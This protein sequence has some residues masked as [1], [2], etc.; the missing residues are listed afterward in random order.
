MGIFEKL[1]QRKKNKTGELECSL[2]NRGGEGNNQVLIWW[3]C[4]HN[5]SYRKFRN[6]FKAGELSGSHS[7]VTVF[8]PRKRWREVPAWSQKM[9]ILRGLAWFVS[10]FSFL[11]PYTMGGM[12]LANKMQN[13]TLFAVKWE[14]ENYYSIYVTHLFIDPYF[15]LCSRKLRVEV[16]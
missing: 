14:I 11:L 2:V 16:E 8:H 3:I 15:F 12:E 1:S 6:L 4:L 13:N 5:S 7:L 9:D 10:H